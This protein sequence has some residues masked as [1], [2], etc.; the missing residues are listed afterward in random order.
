MSKYEV[1]ALQKINCLL[2]IKND[3]LISFGEIITTYFEYSEILYISIN[4]CVGEV[5]EAYITYSYPCAC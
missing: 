4:T 5:Q 3:W 2:I 1:P